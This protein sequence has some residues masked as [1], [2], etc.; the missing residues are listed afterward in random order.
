[1]T[2]LDDADAS[3]RLLP[4][5]LYDRGLALSGIIANR[6]G[7]FENLNLFEQYEIK[8]SDRLRNCEDALI[9]E[10]KGIAFVSCN[11]GRDQWNTVMGT[12][13]PPR[14][15]R[16]GQDSAHIW[17]YDYS[18]PNLPDSQAVRALEL[19]G[20]PNA[21][22]FQPLGI[23]FDVATSTLYVINHSRNSGNIIE[24]FQVSVEDA[25]AKYIQTFKHKLI[26]SP[27]SIHSLGDGKMLITNDHYIGALAS[28]LLSTVE[29]FAGIPGGSVVYVDINNA[30]HTRKLAHLG[31]ANGIAMLDSKTV[32]VAS[33]SK[34]AVQLYTFDPDTVVLETTEYIRIPFF[35]DNL[36]VDSAGK[37]LM[38][39][40]PF[41]PALMAVSKARA[42]CNMHGSE[43][44]KKACECTSSS[45]VAEW[46]RKEG[47]K[48][49]YKND[50]KEFCSSATFARDARR[51][52]SM[53]SGLYERGLLVARG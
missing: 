33:T 9:E 49:V 19:V 10:G 43:K 18:T 11:P 17:V 21:R 42:K 40:H 30:S 1:M 46:D 14:A 25:T 4:P 52:V 12:F 39:G 3:S 5:C 53:I 6:P 24:V 35:V 51:N 36:S 22:D 48:T 44:E 37:L 34:P 20:R 47:V 41:A 16:G 2:H 27:N 7:K 13:A 26:Y 15:R 28:R 45:W 31:F 23:E 32:A 8:F 29:T 50:G 38:A